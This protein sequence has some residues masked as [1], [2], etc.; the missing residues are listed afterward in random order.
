MVI[1]TVVFLVTVSLLVIATVIASR[2][3]TKKN[4]DGVTVYANGTCKV[5]D[6]RKYFSK[7]PKE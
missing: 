7:L 3:P 2:P 6:V 5:T 1:L 4:D